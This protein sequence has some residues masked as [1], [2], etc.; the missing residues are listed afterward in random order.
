MRFTWHDLDG[1][2]HKQYRKGGRADTAELSLTRTT[3]PPR[4]CGRRSGCPV[5]ISPELRSR[6]T[7]RGAAPEKPES[8]I[9]INLS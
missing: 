3:P 4:P 9:R 5:A 1:K 6:H 7:S 2:S 8:E